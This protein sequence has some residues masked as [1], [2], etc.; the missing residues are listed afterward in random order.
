MVFSLIPLECKMV[1]SLIPS[2]YFLD[3]LLLIATCS[4]SIASLPHSL[5][6]ESCEGPTISV[7]GSISPYL[8]DLQI[9]LLK[10]NLCSDNFKGSYL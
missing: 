2:D 7:V 5:G 10:M 1:L 3:I 4:I 8:M 9:Q 6:P